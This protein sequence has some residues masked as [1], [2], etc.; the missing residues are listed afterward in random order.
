MI[1]RN[2]KDYFTYVALCALEKMK[3][4]RTR[5]LNWKN[6]FDIEHPLFTIDVVKGR[7]IE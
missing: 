1:I 6:E 5:H 7:I 3:I 4:S 2:A